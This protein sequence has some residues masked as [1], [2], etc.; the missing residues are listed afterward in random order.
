MEDIAGI[1][2]MYNKI[3]RFSTLFSAS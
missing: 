1:G 2:D 3:T